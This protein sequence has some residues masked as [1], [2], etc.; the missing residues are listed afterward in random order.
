MYTTSGR[1]MTHADTVAYPADTDR[2]RRM[3]I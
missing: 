3:F 2:G 1:V